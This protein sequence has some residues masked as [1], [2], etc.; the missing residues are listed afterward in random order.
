MGLKAGPYDSAKEARIALVE[1]G[2][3]TTHVRGR[4]PQKWAHPTKPAKFAIQ[5]LKGGRAKIVPYPDLKRLDYKTTSDAERQG[6]GL[7][8]DLDPIPRKAS[9]PR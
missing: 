8:L 1:A 9:R 7:R 5:I 2:Y 4:R 6:K 3:T